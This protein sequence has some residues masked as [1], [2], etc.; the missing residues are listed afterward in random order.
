MLLFSL[1][2][3]IMANVLQLPESGYFKV[4]HYYSIRKFDRSTKLDLTTNLLLLVGSVM[5]RR[6]YSPNSKVRIVPIQL[7]QGPPKDISTASA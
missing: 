4:I 2:R 1:G 7:P 3:K 5:C 6:F